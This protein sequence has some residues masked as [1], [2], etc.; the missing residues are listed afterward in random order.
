MTVTTTPRI[1]LRRVSGPPEPD[2]A[3]IWAEGADGSF[4][5]WVSDD[6]A[7]ARLIAASPD[8]N[9]ALL[10]W[11]LV[12]WVNHEV[13][14]MCTFAEALGAIRAAIAKARGAVRRERRG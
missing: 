7:N 6:D 5:G 3:T 13:V 14:E 11:V 2:G 10:V 12:A 4:L 9:A 8:Q 1:R